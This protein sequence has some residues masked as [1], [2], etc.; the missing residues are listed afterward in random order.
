MNCTPTIGIDF[1]LRTIELDGKKIKLQVPRLTR[2]HS[3][4]FA[5]ARLSSS[6]SPSPSP[7]SPLL[8]S[9]LLP[10]PLLF[11][12][13]VSCR[14]LSSRLVSSPLLSSPLLSSPLLS[15][16]LL[17]F[18]P[19]SPQPDSPILL[20]WSTAPSPRGGACTCGRGARVRCGAVRCA[21]VKR[22]GGARR[23]SAPVKGARR[24]GARRWSAPVERAGGARR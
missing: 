22:A 13:L 14:L 5:S 11:S 20:A 10:S 3:P 15:S 8:S 23:W 21:P 6:P 2:S 12:R 4:P 1:K 9:P 18:P 24:G 16:P 19:P 17:P 7:S